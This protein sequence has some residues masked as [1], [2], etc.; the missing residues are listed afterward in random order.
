ML[1]QFL[2]LSALA[3]LGV[4]AM[5]L[6]GRIPQET[7]PAPAASE[8]PA[9]NHVRP[10]AESQAKAKSLYQIDCAICHGENGNGQTD[11]AKSL[12]VTLGDW[13]NPQ[14]LAGKEDGQ[15]FDM[16]RNGKDKM[17]AEANG[18]AKDSEVWN[19]V[20]YIRSFSKAQAGATK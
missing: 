14:T 6:L 7:A 13:S 10:T 11:V 12:G 15:L 5:P 19:L 1:K 8:A 4:V 20:I 17:P 18:R 9:K 16:I 3:L 2:P